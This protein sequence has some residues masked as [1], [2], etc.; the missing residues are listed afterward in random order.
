MLLP[1]PTHPAS[2]CPGQGG[3]RRCCSKNS[4]LCSTGSTANDGCGPNERSNTAQSLPLVF[5]AYSHAAGLSA[6][7]PNRMLM[8][9]LT[10][11]LV[12]PL[13][14][15]ARCFVWVEPQMKT[16]PWFYFKIV[17]RTGALSWSVKSIPH[18]K[19]SSVSSR[20]ALT[21]HRI[22]LWMHTT[23]LRG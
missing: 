2:R 18:P 1:P 8:I 17:F 9:Y 22:C 19:L 23:G 7:T 4:T 13:P 11:L 6:V 16:Q 14:A 3:N 10:N 20:V 15:T 12:S 5:S 21:Q